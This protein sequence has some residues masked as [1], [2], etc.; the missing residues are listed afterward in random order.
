MDWGIFQSHLHSQINLH[1]HLITPSEIDSIIHV[2]IKVVYIHLGFSRP[3]SS[4]TTFLLFFFPRS[5][6]SFSLSPGLEIH[7]KFTV[8]L[9]ISS[10]SH[11]LSCLLRSNFRSSD[12]C[13]LIL[14]SPHFIY[15]TAA[16][17]SLLTPSLKR[18]DR[19][20]TRPN[21]EKDIACFHAI[22]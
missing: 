9:L 5:L 12:L 21:K 3:S 1:T 15:S 4:D 7:R 20:W 2:F 18:S 6:P 17:I 8:I 19:T 22:L 13:N 11:K 16:L 10:G 14:K